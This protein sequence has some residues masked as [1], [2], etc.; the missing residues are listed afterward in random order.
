MY[1]HVPGWSHPGE[2]ELLAEFAYDCPGPWVEIGSYCGRSSC[3][4]GDAAKRAGTVLFAVDPHRGNPEMAPG[5]ECH[6]KDVWAQDLG[7]L[8]VL[9]GSIRAAGLEGIVIPV[10]GGGEAFALTGVRPGFVFIDADH[11]YPGVKQDFVTWSGL[12][13]DG[14]IIALHD[15]DTQG[16]KLVRD[17]AIADGWTLVEQLHSLAVL[18][19]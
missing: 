10:V 14:G 11:M 15:A 9:V 17:E 16:P 1:D 18:T 12:L 4:L 5:R 3:Y 19:R 6:H 8:T 2:F 13:A 7:S